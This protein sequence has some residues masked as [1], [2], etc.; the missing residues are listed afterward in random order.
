MINIAMERST[1]LLM[2]K[3]TISMAIFNSYVSLP[4]GTM[5]FLQASP[6]K[7]EGQIH[8]MG[9][10][11]KCGL[12]WLENMFSQKWGKIVQNVLKMLGKTVKEHFL[13]FFWT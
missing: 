1:M 10:S 7:N 5:D 13:A 3:L 12:K 9:L 8:K 6:S 4:E 2:G 11:S